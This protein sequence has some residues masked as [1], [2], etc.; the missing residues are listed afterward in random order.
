MEQHSLAR[1]RR[2]FS[3]PLKVELF[4]NESQRPH[5]KASSFPGL[6][7]ALST[8]AH[9]G[10]VNVQIVQ[11]RHAL[12]NLLQ[13]F[14]FPQKFEHAFGFSFETTIERDGANLLA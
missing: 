10:A 3:K 5:P 13:I 8:P 11:Q 9:S 2:I 1:V 14:F 4:S 6:P 12:S 7:I